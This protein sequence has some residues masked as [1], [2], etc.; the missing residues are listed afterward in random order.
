ML[1]YVGHDGFYNFAGGLMKL[2][3]TW[4]PPNQ[5]MHEL[6]DFLHYS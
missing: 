1:Q 6:V 3:F 2:W 5:T 4:I